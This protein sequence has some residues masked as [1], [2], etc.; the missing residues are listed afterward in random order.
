VQIGIPSEKEL[1]TGRVLKGLDD[2]LREK[3]EELVF[4]D[5]FG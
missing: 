4:C 5:T 1:E 3:G 2:S